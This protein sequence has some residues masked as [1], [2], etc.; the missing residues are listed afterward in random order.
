MTPSPAAKAPYSTPRLVVYGD[1]RII[2]QNRR[3]SG[4]DNR[5][6]GQNQSI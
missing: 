2:T 1:L 3:T 4:N 6:S 5:A